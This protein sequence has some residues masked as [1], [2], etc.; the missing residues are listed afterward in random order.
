MKILLILAV[1]SGVIFSCKKDTSPLDQHITIEYMG[2]QS[3]YTYEFKVSNNSFITVS[4]VGW[5]EDSPA[6]L[7]SF[8]ADTGWVNLP[9]RCG[10]GLSNFKFKPGDSFLKKVSE[11]VR[12]KDWR[13]GIYITYDFDK[14]D[15]IIWSLVIK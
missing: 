11:P 1:L 5:S 15:E 10:T 13:V 2:Q 4:Y 6:F 14:E 8:L 7:V 3:N 12:D 9:W